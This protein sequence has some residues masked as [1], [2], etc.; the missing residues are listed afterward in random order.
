MT[1]REFGCPRKRSVYRLIQKRLIREYGAPVAA[2]IL[3]RMHLHRDS[4]DGWEFWFEL[5]DDDEE[6]ATTDGDSGTSYAYFDDSARD[7]K[8]PR[9]PGIRIE[10]YGVGAVVERAAYAENGLDADGNEVSP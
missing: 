3:S 10:F 2:S 4:C 6:R 9:R 1:L 8:E 5:D 7:P